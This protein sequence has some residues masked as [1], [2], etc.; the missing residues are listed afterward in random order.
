MRL[1]E[2][3][4]GE[5]VF[6]DTNIFTYLLTNDKRYVD[7]VKSFLKKVEQDFHIGFFNLTVFDETLFNFTKIQVIKRYKIKREDFNSFYK[8][9]PAIIGE[10]DFKP[11]LRLFS[12]DNLNFLT[13]NLILEQITE[14]SRVYS[15][16]PADAIHLATMKANNLIKIAS[17]DPDFERVDW[18]KLYKP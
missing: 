17:N 3:H 15:L 6:I 5:K 18:I 12:M 13:S 10:I 11:V 7:S 8:Q 16:L 14:F 2:I 4:Q 9:N 1:H